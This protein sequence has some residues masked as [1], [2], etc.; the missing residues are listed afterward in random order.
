MFTK[1]LI[2]NRSKFLPGPGRWQPAWA[3]GGAVAHTDCQFVARG[4]PSTTL[5]WSPSPFRGGF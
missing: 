1:I 5:R 3:D 2:A 4:C